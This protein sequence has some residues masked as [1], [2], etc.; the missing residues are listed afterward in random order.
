PTFTGGVTV[1]VGDVNGDGK[2][3]IVT[4]ADAGGGPHV[5]VIDATRLAQVQAN[6]QIADSALLDSFFAYTATFT[7]GVRVATGDVNGDGKADIITGAGAGG[8][9][10]VR[11]F[12]ATNLAE[13]FSFFA[14]ASSY[15]GGVFVAGGDLDGD[16]KADI[17]ASQGVGTQAHVRT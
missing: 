15:T 13:L 16:G 5:K 9:P 11:V 14:F 7:G 6:G 1:A 12:N 17:T 3:D 10:H 4:G 8:G 2:L